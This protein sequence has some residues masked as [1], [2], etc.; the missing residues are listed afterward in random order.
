M[1][2]KIAQ[3]LLLGDSVERIQ[4]CPQDIAEVMGHDKI[5]SLLKTQAPT[6]PS[7]AALLASGSSMF[8]AAQSIPLEPL[9]DFTP[10]CPA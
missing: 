1:K 5:V 9:E 6:K 3:R 8:S 4:L 2:D 7:V 10:K